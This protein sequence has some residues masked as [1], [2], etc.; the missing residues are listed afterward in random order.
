M[1]PSSTAGIR[2]MYYFFGTMVIFWLCGISLLIACGY[3]GSFLQMNSVHNTWLDVIMPHYTHLG[4]GGLITALLALF[5]I[6][7]QNAPL[8]ISMAPGMLSVLVAVSFFK[9]IIFREWFR[10]P[11]FYEPNL[12]F[13]HVSLTMERMFTFPSGHATAAA[14]MFTFLAFYLCSR[15]TYWGLFVALFTISVGYSRVYI[16][17]HY[18]GDVVA[19]SFLG[20]LIGTAA[21]ALT[22]DRIREFVLQMEPDAL[23]RIH[24][25]LYGIVGFIILLSMIRTYFPLYL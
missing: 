24:R 3:Q 22:Y 6:R 8:A 21:I 7:R 18:F 1:I 16:G 5:F 2:S 20:V 9:Q 25:I 11:A 15:S 10:P 17:V 12:D 13:H 14:A 23:L 19:G 4:D